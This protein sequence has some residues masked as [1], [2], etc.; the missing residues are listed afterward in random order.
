[1]KKVNMRLVR[2]LLSTMC[3][4]VVFGLAACG[5]GGGGDSAGSSGPA[6]GVYSGTSAAGNNVLGLI[7]S[8]GRYYFLY[9]EPAT[10]NVIFNV[11]AG[12]GSSSNGSFTSSN[13]L[14]VGLGQMPGMYQTG[15]IANGS[16]SASYAS[17]SSLNGTFTYLPSGGST[18][19]MVYDPASAGTATLTQI[20]NTYNGTFSFYYAGGSNLYTYTP[21]TTFAVS[22]AGTIS[23]SVACYSIPVC[24]S[25]PCPT[26]TCNVNGTITPRSDV[27]A[28]DVSLT[29]GSTTGG[30]TPLDDSYTG[31]AYY[32]ALT[33]RLNMAG[34]SSDNHAIGFK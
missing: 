25:A 30:H 18:V 1:M 3:A 19:T 27:N 8:D 13:L 32:N 7:F 31:A 5:G 2:I 14:S 20:E 17:G 6:T 29:I 10:P 16:F 15:P 23:G 12:S 9:T 26:V 28:Y 11:N 22:S 33:G 24:T 34:I 4:A 21:T